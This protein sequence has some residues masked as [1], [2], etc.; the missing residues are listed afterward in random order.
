M[1]I[2]ISPPAITPDKFDKCEQNEPQNLFPRQ[3]ELPYLVDDA[4]SRIRTKSQ[5]GQEEHSG[6]FPHENSTML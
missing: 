2:T 1:L 6:Q 3:I 4:A 5:Q